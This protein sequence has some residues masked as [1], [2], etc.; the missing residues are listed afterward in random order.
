[1]KIHIQLRSL[2]LAVIGALSMS[3]ATATGPDATPFD[4]KV[5]GNFRQMA[6]KGDFS[7]KVRLRL[8]SQV[9]GSWGLGALADAAGEVL[10]SDGRL[11]ITPGK[12]AQGRVLPAGDT[13]EAA[14][15]V[16]AQVGQW[17]EVAVPANLAQAE[18]EDFV[19]EQAA[20]L[21]LDDRKPFPFLVKGRYPELS[22][23]VLNGATAHAGSV[24]EH[25][26]D[27]MVMK[28]FH[29]AGVSGQ[30]VGFYSGEALEGTISHPGSRF[31]VHFVDDAQFVAGHVDGYVI[32]AGTVLRL[33]LH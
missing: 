10:L 4:L 5:W 26:G 28:Q 3:C 23:H 32:G 27:K 12:D 17:K 19:R 13:D 18:F 15:F 8:I 11:L 31:H 25:M 14:L 21:G 30:L 9:P 24:S 20:T 22:W 16:S 2:L 1:M 33:P 29:Q 6:H 7:G